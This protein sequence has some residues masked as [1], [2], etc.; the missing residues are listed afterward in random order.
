M[1]LFGCCLTQPHGTRRRSGLWLF[2]FPDHH[3]IVIPP[4]LPA[5]IFIFCVITIPLRFHPPIS[6][7]HV[8]GTGIPEFGGLL[9][10]FL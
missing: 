2:S 6:K 4:N 7:N 1:P 10:P 5:I 8:D 9:E 3:Q